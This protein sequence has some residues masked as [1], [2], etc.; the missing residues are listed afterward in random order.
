[1]RWEN[2]P[3]LA[4]HEAQRM[5]VT[6]DSDIRPLAHIAE[7]DPEWESDVL[8]MLQLIRYYQDYAKLPADMRAMLEA[9][10]EE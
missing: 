9:P 7:I 2:N 6:H 10:I 5:L 1:M 4:L 8:S 3:T